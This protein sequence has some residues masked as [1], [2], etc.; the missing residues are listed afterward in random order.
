MKNHFMISIGVDNLDQSIRFYTDLLSFQ[1]IKRLTVNPVTEFAFLIFNDEIEIQLIHR[2]GET[3]PDAS[4]STITLSFE[5]D[6][7]RVEQENLA[8]SEFHIKGEIQTMPTGTK[9]LP[10]SDPNGVRLSFIE[11][12]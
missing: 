6:D 9:I 1:F 4:N 11:E 2:Q 7:I 8:H 3:L 10:F 12:A 5:T